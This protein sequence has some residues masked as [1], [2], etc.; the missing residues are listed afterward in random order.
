MYTSIWSPHYQ[1][2]FHVITGKVGGYE[3][4][5]AHYTYNSALHE[6]FL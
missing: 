2:C 5:N 3:P 6:R 1:F 4:V